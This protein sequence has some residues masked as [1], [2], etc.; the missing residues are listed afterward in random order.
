[1]NWINF[2]LANPF[3]WLPLCRRKKNQHRDLC[4]KDSL[5]WK[6]NDHKMHVLKNRHRIFFCF[7]NSL[8][9]SSLLVTTISFENQNFSSLFNKN[10]NNCK[11]KNWL[12]NRRLDDNLDILLTISYGDIFFWRVDNDLGDGTRF[13]R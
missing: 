4:Y 9:L 2:Y 13:I 12:W 1:M 7:W 11:T 10:I 5:I 3:F 8:T 6:S